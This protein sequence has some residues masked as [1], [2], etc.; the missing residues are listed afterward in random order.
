MKRRSYE[1]LS[2]D[3]LNKLIK[4]RENKIA[5]YIKPLDKKIEDLEDIIKWLD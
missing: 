5:K 3:R 2:K 1:Q 4:E